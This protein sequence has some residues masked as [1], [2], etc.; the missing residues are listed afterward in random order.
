[1][2]LLLQKMR[3]KITRK[4]DAI[5]LI[6]YR[7]E[8]AYQTAVKKHLINLPIISYTDMSLVEKIK[9]EGVVITS[10]EALGIPSTPDILAAAQKLIP[11]IPPSVS[12]HKNEFVVH[13]NS[14]QI[15]EYPEIFSW[16]IEQRLLN[17]AENY[18]G[19]PVAYNGVYFRRD[20]ANKVELNS[21]LWH[22]DKEDTK[23]L[24]III[25]LNDVNEDTGPFQYIPQIL[26]EKISQSLNY[27][28][29]YIQ[30]PTMKSVIS[31]VNYKSCL[32]SAGTVIFAATGSVFH[33]GKI[34]TTADR[35]TI[36]FDYGSRWQKKRSYTANSLTY[37]DL[38]LLASNLPE[39]KRSYIFY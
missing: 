31:P 33:R 32:G 35:F 15:K 3:N 21:R 20:I 27:T 16:G 6:K 24:K 19:L 14:Q 22:I 10:L 23:I 13:A 5:P 30:E 26:T 2:Y 37:K 34:P 25:Y 8:V 9:H 1:M 36:F 7:Q 12:G 18:L 29:G 28:S 17:I 39:Q 38:V 11:K 4:F